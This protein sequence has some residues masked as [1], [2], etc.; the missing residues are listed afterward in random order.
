LVLR[1]NRE[2]FFKKFFRS[3]IAKKKEKKTLQIL[4]EASPK[5]FPLSKILAEKV[6]AVFN[7]GYNQ[8]HVE[9]SNNHVFFSLAIIKYLVCFSIF[10]YF[11]LILIILLI[12]LIFCLI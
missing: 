6:E 5:I 3:K 1:K 7:T 4:A 2:N 9:K 11:I 12:K 10:I 8:K